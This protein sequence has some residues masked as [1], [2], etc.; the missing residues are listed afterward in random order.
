MWRRRAELAA[1]D[2]DVLVVSFEPIERIQWYLEAADFDWPVL[3]DPERAIYRAYGLGSASTLRVWLSPKTA[4]FYLSG[5]AKGRVP[6][7]PRA[8]T[9]QLGGDVVIDGMAILRFA[10]LSTEPADRP[11]VD[12]L[13]AVLRTITAGNRSA[14]RP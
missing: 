1:F 8:D 6:K 7:R 11:S 13:L 3:S 10:H 14:P 12:A 5:L 9:H 2:T 4:W